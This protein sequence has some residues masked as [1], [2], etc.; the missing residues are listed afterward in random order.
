DIGGNRTETVH[1]SEHVRI[2]GNRDKT[3]K[4]NDTLTVNKDRK[5]TINKSRSLNK[6]ARLTLTKP[7]ANL[8]NWVNLSP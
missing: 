5:E 3:V 8:S 2:K 6:A 1:K 4:G 7:T